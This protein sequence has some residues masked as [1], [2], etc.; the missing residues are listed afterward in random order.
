MLDY[1]GV[2]VAVENAVAEAIGV[3]NYQTESNKNDGVALFF[4]KIF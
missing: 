4:R 3:A 1:V 2:G